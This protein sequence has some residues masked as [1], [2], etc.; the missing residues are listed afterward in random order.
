MRFFFVPVS[1]QR[2]KPPQSSISG[3][4]MQPPKSA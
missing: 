1:F 3:C 4:K 2:P